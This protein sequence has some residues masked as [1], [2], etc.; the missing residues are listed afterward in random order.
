MP[1]RPGFLGITWGWL[2]VATDAHFHTNGS[3]L[4]SM[5]PDTWGVPSVLMSIGGNNGGEGSS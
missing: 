2:S 5:Q 4:K 1:F 3:R